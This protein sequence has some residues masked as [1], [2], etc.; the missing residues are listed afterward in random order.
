MLSIKKKTS[1][2]PAPSERKTGLFVDSDNR[3][4]AHDD[5]VIDMPPVQPAEAVAPSATS[6]PASTGLGLRFVKKKSID[7]AEDAQPLAARVTPAKSA[8]L[9]GLAARWGRT[10]KNKS[11]PKIEPSGA[12]SAPS[13][14]PQSTDVAAVVGESV[15]S[16]KK[17]VK[18]KKPATPASSKAPR[19]AQGKAETSIVLLTELDNGRQL[20]WQL[21]EKKLVQLTDA[22]T[23]SAYSFSKED[24]RYRTASALTYKQA[25]DL[26]MQ[27]IGETVQIVNRSKDLAAVYATRQDRVLG[28]KHLLFPAQ[29]AL[30]RLLTEKKKFG[31]GLICGFLLKDAQEESS[32]AVLFY[33]NADG[34]A[35]KPQISVNPDSMEFVL[36]QFAAARKVDKTTT[37]VVLYDNAELL[38]SLAGAQAYPNEPVWQGI[39][40]RK[41]LANVALGSG[42]IAVVMAAWAGMQFQQVQ[43]L[44]AKQA[45]LGQQV[46]RMKKDIG[47][48]LTGSVPEFAKAITLDPDQLTQQAQSFYVQDATL[49]LTATLPDTK[50]TLSMPLARPE[51]FNNQPTTLNPIGMEQQQRL[52]NFKAPDGCEVSP[53]ATTGAL[54]ETQLTIDCKSSNSAFSSYRSE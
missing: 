16:L 2:P 49:V 23:V 51:T 14:E 3:D 18:A 33:V 39:P 15:S 45:K 37:E 7:A 6:F 4:E 30:D 19:F 10:D 29:Q 42:A 43:T 27:D 48:A 26:A 38:Q 1:A 5:L 46:Q 31:Q 40:V 17:T 28:V 25:S 12:G 22:P 9:S 20:Y 41:V 36:A 21:E 8:G 35:S 44:S 53:L 54:N 24:G 50:F 52:L 47:E 34:E 13:A 11:A 32:V